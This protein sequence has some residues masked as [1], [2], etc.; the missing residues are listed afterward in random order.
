MAKVASKK[1]VQGVGVND[2]DYLVHTLINGVRVRCA[3]YQTWINMLERCYNANVQKMQPTYIGCTVANDWLS[4][5]KFK[6]WMENEEWQGK[7]LDKDILIQGNK[8]YSPSTCIFVTRE[9]NSLLTD[10]YNAR[11]LLPLGVTDVTP[12]IKPYKAQCKAYGKANHIGYY[13]TPE[14]AHEAYKKFK[15]KYI[16]EIANQQ[17]EP[18]RTALL[19]Y[20]IEG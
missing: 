12:R 9:I 8:S 6:L 4:L 11:G 20:K 3:F 7:Q 1:L 5:S 2:A 19:N 16:A 15:Y 18:L 14:E 13:D 10:R 17:I